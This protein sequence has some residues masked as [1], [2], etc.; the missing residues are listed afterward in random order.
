M[1]EDEDQDDESPYADFDSSQFGTPL[2]D[3]FDAYDSARPASEAAPPDLL[4]QKEFYLSPMTLT[5]AILSV[6][7]PIASAAACCVLCQVDISSNDAC[8]LL[9]LHLLSSDLLMPF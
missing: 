4:R 6:S 1:D 2:P 8:S 5:E 9:L 3:N 7:N